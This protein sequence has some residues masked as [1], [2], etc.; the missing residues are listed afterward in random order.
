MK[1]LFVFFFSVLV[2]SLNLF[3]FGYGIYAKFSA[4]RYY[5][6]L[7]VKWLLNSAL[8]LAVQ[9][10]ED[11]GRQPELSGEDTLGKDRLFHTISEIDK[12][13][14]YVKLRVKHDGREFTKDYVCRK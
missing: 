6:S 10:Y 2:I 14:I 1:K 4:D 8:T 3:M 12:D 13:R 7:K 11:T 5:D 9:D